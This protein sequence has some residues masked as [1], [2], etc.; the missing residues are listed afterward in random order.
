MDQRDRERVRK[1]H[2]HLAATA[3]RPVETGASRWLGEAEAVVADAVGENVPPEA[4]AKR[5]G[6]V[7]N[8]LANVEEIADPEAGEHV[9][10]ARDLAGELDERLR[11]G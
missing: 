11:P 2:A 4:V 8:L 3:E 7:R 1:L 10:A 6:Q 5:V 9:A